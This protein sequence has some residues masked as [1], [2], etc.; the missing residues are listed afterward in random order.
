MSEVLLVEDKRLTSWREVVDA[1]DYLT[2][3]NWAFRGHEH[4]EWEPKTS[5]EREFGLKGAELEQRLLQRFVRTAPRLLPNHLIPNDNDAAA[6]LALIQ[7]YGGPT[8]LLDVTRSPY[9]ALFFAF[10]PT[11]NSDRAVWAIEQ[12]WCMT[13]CGRIMAEAEGRPF[14]DVIGRTRHGQAQLVYSLVH[15]TPYPDPLFASLKAFNGVFPLDPWKPETRQSAQQAMFLCAANPALTF[16]EN[17]AALRRP[18]EKVV[19]RFV[20]PASLREE[21][22]EQLSIM[23][24]T[25][26]TLFPDLGGLARS[27]RTHPVRRPTYASIPPWESKP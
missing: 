23:N 1:A 6:W 14:I 11:G 27:L 9:V 26:A 7:H 3:H 25:A 15:R 2:G 19:Y 16:V 10:E 5:L 13:E 17:L 18:T 20:L 24:V 12:L 8:R 21:V 22:L 4:A